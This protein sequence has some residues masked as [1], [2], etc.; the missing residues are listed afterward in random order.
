MMLMTARN[1]LSLASRSGMQLGDGKKVS[2]HGNGA[3]G[4]V[5][6]DDTDRSARGVV[7][8]LPDA[9]E[10]TRTDRFIGF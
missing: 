8:A 3:E 4:G 9:L 7:V 6:N 1:C 2:S 5:D 10:S